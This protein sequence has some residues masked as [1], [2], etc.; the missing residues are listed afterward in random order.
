MSTKIHNGYRLA[1][2]THPFEFI[3]EA[4]TAG[5]EV[6]NQI[7][8]HLPLLALVPLHAGESEVVLQVGD[9]RGVLRLGI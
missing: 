9:S 1:D 6:I 4:C 8:D 2:G 5:E 3:Q 7:G